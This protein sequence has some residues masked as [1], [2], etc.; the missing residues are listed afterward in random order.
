MDAPVQEVKDLSVGRSAASWPR[1]ER[2]RRPPRLYQ[3]HSATIESGVL[4]DA[5]LIAELRALR[6]AGVA[7]GLSV[8]GPRQA[9]TIDR[10]LE[11][12]LFDTVQATWNLQSGPRAGA[13]SAP[14]TP[15]S[16]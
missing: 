11:L 8:T 10:A 5:E 12:G 7:I 15:A 9:D 2:S 4:D 16:A 3:I 13:W 14:T 6:D 1:R